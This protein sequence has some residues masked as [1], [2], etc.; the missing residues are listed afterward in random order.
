MNPI[1]GC[2]RSCSSSNLL[3]FH[4]SDL[5][6]SLLSCPSVRG[7][8]PAAAE[9]RFTLPPP[10][11]LPPS[12]GALSS[13]GLSLPSPGHC[14]APRDQDHHP[15]SPHWHSLQRG[16]KGRDSLKAPEQTCQT[17]IADL[18]TP[19]YAGGSMDNNNVEHQKPE[20]CPQSS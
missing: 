18:H 1:K 17:S 3:Q 16:R 15:S 12:S 8:A 11:S 10:P 4:K 14:W 13:Q 6:S 20:T 19:Q 5:L 2:A 9:H 7:P